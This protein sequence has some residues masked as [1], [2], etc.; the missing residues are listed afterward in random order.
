[1]CFLQPPSRSPHQTVLVIAA[2]RKAFDLWRRENGISGRQYRY[3]WRREQLRGYSWENAYLLVVDPYPGLT[4][5]LYLDA[6]TWQR[7]PGFRPVF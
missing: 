3:V 6:F 2:N 4:N 7:F 5:S 1:M